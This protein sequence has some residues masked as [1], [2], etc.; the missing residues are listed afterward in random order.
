MELLGQNKAGH[1]HRKVVI[2]N[3]AVFYKIL[4][5]DQQ[6]KALKGQYNFDHPDAF[7]NELALKTLKDILDGKIVEVP[8]YDFVTNSRLSVTVYPADI[9]LF[10]GILVFYNQAIRDLFQLKVFVDTD[11]D[12]RLTNRVLRDTKR[13][14]DLEQIL[15]QYTMFV[16]PAFEAFSLPTK[17]YADVIIRGG[18]DNINAI[19]TIVQYI[20]DVL[21][22]DICKWQQE[23][24]N[25]HS[26]QQKRSCPEELGT[27]S[28]N[29]SS[30]RVHL[31]P[32]CQPH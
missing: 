29:C 8:N 3:Q 1:H 17:K 5:P 2:L 20:Q 21:N 14:R 9:V 19:N 27:N 31:E 28:V 6:A 15:A 4:T 7:D 16:K 24:M 10:E 11:S 22:V 23:P 32:N 13:G 25:G 12:V 26:R 30:K 18:A